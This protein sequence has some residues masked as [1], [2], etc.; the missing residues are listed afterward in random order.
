M[1]TG[2]LE[3]SNLVH[4][5]VPSIFP[6][7]SMNG[8]NENVGDHPGTDNSTNPQPMDYPTKIPDPTP[9]Q[10]KVPTGS[11]MTPQPTTPK[12]TDSP[13]VPALWD[14][15]PSFPQKGWDRGGYR[16]RE[17]CDWVLQTSRGRSATGTSTSAVPSC[18]TPTGLRPV[19][20]T[21]PCKTAP[22]PF[23]GLV[24]DGGEVVNSGWV[25]AVGWTADDSSESLLHK[26]R[27]RPHGY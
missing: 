24:V 19:W 16:E 4:L 2:C 20:Q 11:S 17:G 14:N 7:C 12:P 13:T 15:H 27:S 6:N 10:L 5:E 3:T 23:T 21:L 26:R 1:G 25:D 22:Q 8:I 18:A 9:P